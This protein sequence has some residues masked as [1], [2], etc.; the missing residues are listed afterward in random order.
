M[1]SVALSPTETRSP[2]HENLTE[3][4]QQFLETFVLLQLGVLPEKIA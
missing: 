4:L 3:E 2:K 1:P